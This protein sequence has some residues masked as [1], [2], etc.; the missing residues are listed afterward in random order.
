MNL[1]MG[2]RRE[3]SGL[4][5]E[6]IGVLDMHTNGSSPVCTRRGSRLRSRH[7]RMR[8]RSLGY[9]KH[10]KETTFEVVEN[11]RFSGVV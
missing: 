8:V 5:R 3:R 11:Q 1:E 6:I 9:L 2:F 4:R 7:T 10:I